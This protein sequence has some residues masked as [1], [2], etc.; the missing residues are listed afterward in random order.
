MSYKIYF[1]ISMF[2]MLLCGYFTIIMV[3]GN[4]R[5]VVDNIAQECVCTNATLTTPPATYTFIVDCPQSQ[6][7]RAWDARKPVLQNHIAYPCFYADNN[8]QE[9]EFRLFTPIYMSSFPALITVWCILCF[10]G[11]VSIVLSC[12]ITD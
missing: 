3:S 1:Y 5:T 8:I 4:P 2:V 7:I 10:S 6:F 12:L 11:C 9:E